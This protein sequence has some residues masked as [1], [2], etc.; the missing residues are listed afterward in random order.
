MGG[1]GP[2]GCHDHYECQRCGVAVR[3]QTKVLLNDSR[4][5]VCHNDGNVRAELREHAKS[6]ETY[7]KEIRKRIGDSETQIP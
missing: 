6:V 2:E 4:I 5:P 7:L 1:D 3:V